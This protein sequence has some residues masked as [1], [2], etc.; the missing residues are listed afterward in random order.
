M[1]QKAA[2]NLIKR[3][4]LF[5]F[6]LVL[7]VNISLTIW[8]FFNLNVKNFGFWV[9]M[10]GAVTVLFWALGAIARTIK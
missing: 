6:V 5:A 7:T 3:K 9:S 4:L 8:G 10:A 2:I 1:N